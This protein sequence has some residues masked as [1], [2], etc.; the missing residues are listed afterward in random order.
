MSPVRVYRSKLER[1]LVRDLQGAVQPS[2]SGPRGLSLRRGPSTDQRR[3]V[4]VWLTE[5]KPPATTPLVTRSP[6]LFFFFMDL[7]LVGR[8]KLLAT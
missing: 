8:A 6:E 3:T 7:S 1:V 4:R 5:L 2:G